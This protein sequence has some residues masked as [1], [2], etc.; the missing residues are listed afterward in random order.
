MLSY[1]MYA[2]SIQQKNTVTIVQ[3][4]VEA[5]QVFAAHFTYYR[6]LVRYVGV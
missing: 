1:Q 2:D 4:S 3:L 6:F 5:Q